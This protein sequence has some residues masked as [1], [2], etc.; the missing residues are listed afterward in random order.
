MRQMI[1]ATLASSIAVWGC[2]S[3]Q[4]ASAPSASI[5]STR[6]SAISRPGFLGTWTVTGHL[7]PGISAMSE[8]E[9]SAWR[10]TTL[11]LGEALAISKENR[12]AA[13]RYSTEAVLTSQLL[14]DFKLPPGRLLALDSLDHATVLQVSCN[15]VPWGAMGGRLISISAAA[16][17]APWD[18]VFFELVRVR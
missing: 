9:A 5:G 16:A 7:I 2:S 11:Q 4:V 13:P 10:G 6:E 3:T 12:C 15:G 18:G 17:L 14:A 1:A 8:A